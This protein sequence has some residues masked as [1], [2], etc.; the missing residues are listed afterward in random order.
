MKEKKD[1][2]KIIERILAHVKRREKAK[3]VKIPIKKKE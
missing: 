2:E 1:I 3:V